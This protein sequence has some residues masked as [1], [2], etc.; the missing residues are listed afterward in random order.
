MGG[1]RGRTGRQTAER[2]EGKMTELDKCGGIRKKDELRTA[3]MI[4][5]WVPG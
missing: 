3:R 4:L 5:A 2:Q 1:R